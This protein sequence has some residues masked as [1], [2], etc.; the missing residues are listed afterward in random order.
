MPEYVYPVKDATLDLIQMALEK[1]IVTRQELLQRIA[2]TK[3]GPFVPEQMVWT[4]PHA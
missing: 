1:G 3:D 4:D 2:D